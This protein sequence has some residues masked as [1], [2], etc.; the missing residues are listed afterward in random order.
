MIKKNFKFLLILIFLLKFNNNY[1]LLQYE[2]KE[3]I[4]ENKFSLKQ[5]AQFIFHY[6]QSFIILLWVILLMLLTITLKKGINYYK[7]IPILTFKNEEIFVKTMDI[8]KIKTY[9]IYPLLE[10]LQEKY[11]IFKDL[12][13]NLFLTAN[14]NQANFKEYVQKIL[15]IFNTNFNNYKKK[16]HIIINDENDFYKILLVALQN[17]IFIN[18]EPIEIQQLKDN[19][20]SED[21]FLL[22]ILSNPYKIND[23][24]VNNIIVSDK[25]FKKLMKSINNEDDS[26]QTNCINNVEILIKHFQTK[27]NEF[28]GL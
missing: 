14:N 1:S 21:I 13:I 24:I 18:I 25:K 22:N 16:N 28:F 23:E 26:K 7:K 27:Y 11:L 20:I 19:L 3:T 6:S 10:I 9:G 15:K 5:I 12:D 17:K 2:N 4:D 8:V